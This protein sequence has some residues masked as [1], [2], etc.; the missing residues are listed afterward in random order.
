MLR[1]K[2]EEERWHQEREDYY[3]IMI[4]K[5]KKILTMKLEFD[6]TRGEHV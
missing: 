4:A 6:K 5:E 2:K 3:A 1:A